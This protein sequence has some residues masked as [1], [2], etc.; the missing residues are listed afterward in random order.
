MFGNALSSL[1]SPQALAGILASP[2]LKGIV[3]PTMRMGGFPALAGLSNLVGRGGTD[4]ANIMKGPT[5]TG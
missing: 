2:A 4:I 3:E 1:R 5:S